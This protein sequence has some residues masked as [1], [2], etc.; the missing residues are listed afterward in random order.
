MRILRK[1][2]NRDFNKGDRT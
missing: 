2:E 1:I